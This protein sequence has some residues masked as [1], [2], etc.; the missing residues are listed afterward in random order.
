MIQN[1]WMNLRIK[2]K[3]DNRIEGNNQTNHIYAE[4]KWQDSLTTSRIKQKWNKTKAI[5]IPLNHEQH[6]EIKAKTV[7]GRFA[8]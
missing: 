4:C 5:A 6:H 7:T 1:D 8:W 2:Q 3:I